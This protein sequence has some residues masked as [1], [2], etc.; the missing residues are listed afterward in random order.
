MGFFPCC[1]ALKHQPR[2]M[3]TLT[4]NEKQELPSAGTHAEDCALSICLEGIMRLLST[5]AIALVSAWIGM[6]VNPAEAQSFNERFS[7]IPKANA[8]EPNGQIK[9]VPQTQPP[10]EAES[11]RGSGR[12][13]ETR[14]VK[15]SFTGKSSYYSYRTRK[16]GSASSLNPN[17]RTVAHR[18]P[19]FGTR[20]RV[21]Y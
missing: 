17:L 15:G 14:S 10:N 13:S 1:G 12:R 11:T 7:I 20:V 16:T 5:I 2:P 3:L 19:P 18:R 9:P 8:A 21:K 6:H 4:K